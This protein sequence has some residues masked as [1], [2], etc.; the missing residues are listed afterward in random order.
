V[1][2]RRGVA[3]RDEPERHNGLSR[4]ISGCFVDYRDQSYIEHNVQ[5]LLGQRI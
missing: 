1:S 4:D 2:P 5:E 3:R